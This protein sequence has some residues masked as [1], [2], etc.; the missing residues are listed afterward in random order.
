MVAGYSY[1]GAKA[2]FALARYNANG[3]L[4]GDCDGTGGDNYVLAADT[5]LNPPGPLTGIFR[6]F[7]DGTGNGD[8]AGPDF[9]LFLNDYLPTVAPNSP[10][11]FDNNGDV[12]GPDFL[13]FRNRY[14]LT[15][16]GP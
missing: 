12:A 4:D 7:G 1:H 13:A 16:L 14:L 10:F 5:T 6:F 2:D 8:V 3:S 15:Y 9:L 11:D